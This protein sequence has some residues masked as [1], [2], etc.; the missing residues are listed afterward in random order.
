MLWLIGGQVFMS[1][2]A[3]LISLALLHSAEF[4][5][6]EAPPRRGAVVAELREG[7]RFL[8]SKREMTVAMIVVFAFISKHSIS[9]VPYQHPAP[10]P[11]TFKS[12]NLQR[13]EVKADEFAAFV[14]GCGWN[15]SAQ[16]LPLD[17]QLEL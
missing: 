12:Q 5:R 14:C 11:W 9:S 1:F 13:F 16:C 8:L 4:R 3:V 2:V 10:I 7:V 17:F 6:V 15:C